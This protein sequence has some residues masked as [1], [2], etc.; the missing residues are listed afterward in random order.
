MV[1]DNDEIIKR[2]T[3]SPLP[4]PL[5]QAVTLQST[6]IPCQVWYPQCFVLFIF[7]L[8]VFFLIFCLVVFCL[9]LYFCLLSYLM[10]YL[11]KA[12][13]LSSFLAFPP[14]LSY[15][16]FTFPS[17]TPLWMFAVYWSTN[18]KLPDNLVLVSF[19]GIGIS[20]CVCICICI[21]ICICIFFLSPPCLLGIL[22]LPPHI[23]NHS[24]K[25]RRWW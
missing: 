23:A 1:D 4:T 10:I 2:P 25:I 14:F 21:S 17:L 18:M 8:F 3:T 7:L 5:F 15:F 22:G 11:Y 12:H 9:Y 24:L 13:K 16:K 19:F 20:T 6:M